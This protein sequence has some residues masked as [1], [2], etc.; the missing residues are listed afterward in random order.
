MERFLRGLEG[1]PLTYAWDYGSLVSQFIIMILAGLGL[2]AIVISAWLY[3]TK[4]SKSE[5]LTIIGLG[6][7]GLGIL[8]TIYDLW[9]NY[10]AIQAT[11]ITDL[12]VL[13]PSIFKIISILFLSLVVLGI[14][15]IG[16]ASL[17]PNKDQ[18]K[19]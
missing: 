3:F 15:L 6:S 10:N 18:N 2:L 14:T 19:T 4:K 16:N 11:G 7:L 9:I 17:K 5:I 13:A 1:V 12:A 8:A